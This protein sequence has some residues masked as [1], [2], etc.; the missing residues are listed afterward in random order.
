VFY[1]R[2]HGSRKFFPLWTPAR[3][4]TSLQGLPQAETGS[5]VDLS[6]KRG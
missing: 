2:Y 1:L 4:A 6:V 3:G 5:T